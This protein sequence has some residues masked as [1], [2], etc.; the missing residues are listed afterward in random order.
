MVMFLITHFELGSCF[1]KY[2]FNL[3]VFSDKSLYIFIINTVYGNSNFRS[4]VDI[5]NLPN[6]GFSNF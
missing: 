1:D 5:Q 6:F 2:D 3:E 4:V